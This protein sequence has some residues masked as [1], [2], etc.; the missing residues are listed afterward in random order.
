MG[1]DAEGPADV[2]AERRWTWG[3]AAGRM[4]GKGKLK[5]YG[6]FCASLFLCALGIGL[7]TNADLGTSPITS[8]P[9]VAGRILGWTLGTLT[10]VLN[11][12]FLAWQ[13]IILGRDFHASHLLQ[14]P[15]VFLFSVFIDAGMLLTAPL[16]SAVYWRQALMCVTGCAVLG[17]G[18]SIE[19]VCNVTVLPGEGIVIAIAY[20]YKRIFDR[21][22]VLFDVALVALAVLLG[23]AFLGRVDGVREGTVIS[24]LLVGTFV[25][26]FSPWARR[27]QTALDGQG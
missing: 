16:T 2:K 17:L 26:L 4:N 9:Y 7:I 5:R 10:F 1:G 12:F 8:L 13:K 24:A 11:V 18:I 3:G 25:R 14:L 15:A 20:R 23:L 19:I 27:L 6:A 22:K 21:I